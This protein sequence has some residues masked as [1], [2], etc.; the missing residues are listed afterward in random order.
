[1]AC[2]G[3]DIQY[4]DSDG[5]GLHVRCTGY[6]GCEDVT[7]KIL[8]RAAECSGYRACASAHITTDYLVDC[9]G[10]NGC[11][12]ANMTLIFYFLMNNFFFH[13][14][15]FMHIKSHFGWV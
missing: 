10:Y 2:K 15:I 1:M 7:W 14:M 5:G 9:L 11:A 13:S 6:S 3:S 8:T 12:Q 4:P